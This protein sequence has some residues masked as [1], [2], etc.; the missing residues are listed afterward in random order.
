MLF[1][2]YF[3]SA[4]ENLTKNFSGKNTTNNNDTITHLG[5]NFSQFSS[6]IKLNN[7]TTYEIGKIIHSL[8]CTDSYGCD[9]ISSR[10]L[11]N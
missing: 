3:S 2:T 6:S 9:E 8:K 5:Q 10:I 1:N 7:T 4:A 11:I